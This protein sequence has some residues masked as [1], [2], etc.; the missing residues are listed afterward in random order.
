MQNIW[1]EDDE[2]KIVISGK[3]VA[4]Y[5]EKHDLTENEAAKRLI[6]REIAKG[7]L[8]KKA[9]YHVIDPF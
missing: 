5:A 1:V 4:D 2:G 7:K 8:D 9:N 3:K 6:N